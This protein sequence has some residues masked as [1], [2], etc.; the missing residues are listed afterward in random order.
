MASIRGIP[1]FLLSPVLTVCSNAGFYSCYPK[2]NF[3]AMG[4]CCEREIRKV[5]AHECNVYPIICSWGT[6]NKTLEERIAVFKTK[7]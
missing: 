2:A 4:N 1:P 5:V 6:G 3:Q 7:T